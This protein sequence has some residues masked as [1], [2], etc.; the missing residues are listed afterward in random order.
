MEEKNNCVA[1]EVREYKCTGQ[2]SSC[3]FYKK[4]KGR[5]CNFF[6]GYMCF[7]QEAMRGADEKLDK[8]KVGE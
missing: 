8:N 7:S 4:G 3:S 5:K 1:V 2:D 6:S